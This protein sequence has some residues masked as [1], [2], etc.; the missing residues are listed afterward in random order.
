[1]GLRHYL[2][3]NL[4]RKLV[5]LCLAALIWFNI[6]FNNIRSA[7][8]TEPKLLESAVGSLL[9]KPATELVTGEFAHIPITL[10]SLAQDG[11]AFKLD[12]RQAKVT[13]S[14][15]RRLLTRLTAKDIK[16]MVDLTELANGRKADPR[17]D[18]IVRTVQ[19]RAPEG[20]SVVKV[21]PPV[22]LVEPVSLP[23]PAAKST[24]KTE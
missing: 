8:T 7:G 12:A 17:A 6:W 20:I 15:Q 14:G 21:E 1:M 18:L 11:R 10:V 19:V 3:N 4:G 23:E 5:S 9:P 16:A 22:V 2:L 24:E 13:V